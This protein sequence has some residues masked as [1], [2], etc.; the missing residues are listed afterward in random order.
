MKLLVELGRKGHQIILS[1]LEDE[2]WY[3]VR[4]L[5]IILGQQRDAIPM[6]AVHN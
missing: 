5:L 1:A 6:K 2:R 4:N 3:L